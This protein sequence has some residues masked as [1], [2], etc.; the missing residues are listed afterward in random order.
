MTNALLLSCGSLLLALGASEGRLL[1]GEP[2]LDENFVVKA[3]QDQPQD[4]VAPIV[5]PPQ[6]PSASDRIAPAPATGDIVVPPQ[7][8]QHGSAGHYYPA[9][10]HGFG[11]WGWGGSYFDYTG[12]RYPNTWG[13]LWGYGA[14]NRVGAARL[15]YLMWFSRGRTVPPLAATVRAGGPDVIY[16]DEPVGENMRSGGR[17]TLSRLMADSCTWV[18]ARFWGVEDSTERFFEQS[19]GNPILGRPFFNPTLGIEDVL[20]IA[21]PGISTGG[22]INVLSKN[23]M[24]SFEAWFRRTWCQDGCNNIDYLVGYQFARIDDFLWINS[25]QTPLLQIGT[26]PPNSLV[27]VTDSFGTENEF[28]G[29]VVGVVWEGRKD[30]WSLEV[31]GKFALGAMR[32]R[33]AINGTTVIDPANGP[34]TEEDG[35]FLAAPSNEGVRQRYQLAFIPELNVNLCYNFS[36]CWKIWVGYSFVYF[37]DV[38]LAGNQIDRAVDLSP[39]ATQP[40]FRLV[41]NDFLIQGINIGAEYRW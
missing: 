9:F 23:D 7:A 32:Q 19:N 16:G 24:L 33:I 11:G 5:A 29:G 40:Q 30:S 17:I 20:I 10:G 3:S 4:P 27:S 34:A 6:V 37:S 8:T 2:G 13:G 25:L 1:A 18:E 38:V 14:E 22:S 41:N 39:Q 12:V 28:H 36:P 26:F 21:A 35:G 15:E 31:L